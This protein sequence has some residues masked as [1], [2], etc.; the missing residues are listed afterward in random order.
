M[1]EDTGLLRAL[2]TLDPHLELTLGSL[3]TLGLCQQEEAHQQESLLLQKED[4]LCESDLH[5]RME[6]VPGLEGEESLY[7]MSLKDE[8]YGAREGMFGK[9]DLDCFEERQVGHDSAWGLLVTQRLS[10]G[11]FLVIWNC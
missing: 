4:T 3:S 2:N 8:S 5:Q 1:G 7:L 10:L 11:D 9:G 6:F